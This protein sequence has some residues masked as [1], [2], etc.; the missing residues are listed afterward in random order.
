MAMPYPVLI[1]L[2]VLVDVLHRR[3]PFFE[4]SAG[5]LA[6]AE[7]GDIE[8]WMAAH[9]VATLFY[10]I[11]K[12]TSLAAA[13]V[14]LTRLIQ[15]LKIAS[16]DARV[17]EQALALPYRDFEDAV[18][19]MAGVHTG[20]EYIVTRDRA[21]FKLGPLPILTPTELLVLLQSNP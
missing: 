6:A 21:G 10:L 5:V 13:H 3:E 11:A 15:F 7:A 9:S 4:K 2:D 19:M 8:G 17:I 20:V 1:D 14:H 16:V 18:Q 12:D